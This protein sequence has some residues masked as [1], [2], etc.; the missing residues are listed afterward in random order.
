MAGALGVQLGGTN[1]YAGLR[2]DRPLLGDPQEPLLAAHITRA[3]HIMTVAY[4]IAIAAC[5]GFLWH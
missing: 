1:F 4:L 5:L 3:Q 2:H